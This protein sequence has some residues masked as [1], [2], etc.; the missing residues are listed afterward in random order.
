MP[1][2]SPQTV[3]ILPPLF[4]HLLSVWLISEALDDQK[5]I[6]IFQFLMFA[7]NNRNTNNIKCLKGRDVAGVLH[8]TRA[9]RDEIK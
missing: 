9:R 3:R 8:H 4:P 6:R 5:A 2:A 1:T 7:N